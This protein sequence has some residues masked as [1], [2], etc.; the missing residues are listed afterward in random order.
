MKKTSIFI[1]LLIAIGLIFELTDSNDSNKSTDQT[2]TG[3]ASDV[4]VH[5]IDIGQGDSILIQSKKEN[6]LIDAGNK[7]AGDEVV[8]Y[9]QK[10]NVTTLDAVVSTHPD[11]D[12][13]GG[14]AEVINSIEVKKVYAPKVSHTTIAYKN[15][16]TAV[17]NQGLKITQAKTGVEIQTTEEN[18]SLKFI[19]PV[20]TY[21]QSDLNDWSAVL[22]LQ[23]GNNKFLFTGDAEFPAEDDMLAKNLIPQ[24][25]VLKVSHHGA[26]EASSDAFLAKA[27]PTYAAISVSATNGYGHPTAVTLNRLKKVGA[28]VYRTD[29]QGNIV[30]KSTGSEISVKENQ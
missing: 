27:K 8:A 23:N 21:S 10:N 19:A 14:L 16:L 9:L 3:K 17:K 18:L 2:F 15:F 7:G 11:A 5:I 25:D 1:V 28:K 20:T 26:E 6:I 12:H 30:F 4:L 13:V 22:L 24:V 29:K